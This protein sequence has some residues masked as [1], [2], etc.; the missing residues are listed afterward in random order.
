MLYSIAKQIVN[1]DDIKY[2]LIDRD[3]IRDFK[4]A[5]ATGNS[6]EVRAVINSLPLGT[7][8]KTKAEYV[9]LY[10]GDNVKNL[11]AETFQVVPF[12]FFGHFLENVLRLMMLIRVNK[13]TN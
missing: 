3:K 2:I 1:S 9:N 7:V 12:I 6:D 5:S 10:G 8:L 13:C 11:D 4:I